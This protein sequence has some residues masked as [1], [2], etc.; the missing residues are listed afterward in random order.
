MAP[1]KLES[2]NIFK[3]LDMSKICGFPHD[4]PKDA[5]S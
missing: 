4:L 1:S 3:P 2:D 5:I